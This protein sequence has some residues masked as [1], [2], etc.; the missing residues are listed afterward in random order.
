MRVRV[1]WS[2]RSYAELVSP[3]LP[4][5][6]QLMW[7]VVSTWGYELEDIKSTLE[8]YVHDK[9][10]D[11]KTT[12]VWICF[13]CINQHRVVEMQQRGESVP[14]EAFEA[15]FRSRVSGTG[16]ILVM[17]SPWN[18]PA[19]LTRVWV[20]TPRCFL[21]MHQVLDFVHGVFQCVFELYVADSGG[22]EVEIVM[23]R[24]EKLAL[25]DAVGNG[26]NPFDLLTIDVEAAQASVAADK[27][28]ILHL[29]E[30]GVG[31]ARF[32]DQVLNKINSFV[33][34]DAPQALWT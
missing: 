28:T 2:C 21:L 19:N 7:C 34:Y 20:S 17:L 5:C 32:N 12:F 11:S 4:H 23:P 31:F 10:I 8:S 13:A 18:D 30:E 25:L 9:S 33:L 29:V 1:S 22:C 27:T 15:E 3:L 26:I 24:R 14:V 16:H 6:C